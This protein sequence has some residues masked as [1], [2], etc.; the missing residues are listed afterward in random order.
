M[1]PRKLTIGIGLALAALVT[2]LA[3]AATA[4][5]LI[6]V[7]PG[8]GSPVTYS[9]PR[10]PAVKKIVRRN[11]GGYPLNGHTHVRVTAAPADE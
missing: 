2:S 1:N 3:F 4:S 9:H 8:D 10:K 6:P 7:D 5:A 11:T